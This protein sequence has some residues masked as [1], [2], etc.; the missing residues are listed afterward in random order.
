MGITA[1]HVRRVSQKIH[2]KK[3][4]LDWVAVLLKGSVK[5]LKISFSTSQAQKKKQKTKNQKW[6]QA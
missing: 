3:L 4:E 6:N 2:R 1:N 5:I